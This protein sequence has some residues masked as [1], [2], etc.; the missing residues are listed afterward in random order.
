MKV[1]GFKSEKLVTWNIQKYLINW[2]R[3]VSGP[4]LF[5]KNFLY[6][7]WKNCIVIEEARIPSS[8]LRLDLTNLTKKIIVE[9]SPDKVHLEFNKFMHGGRAG[10]LKKLKADADKMV[11]A[12]SNGFLFVELYDED[13]KNLSVNYLKEKFGVNL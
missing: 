4:Q 3:K 10:F 13:L 11:W 9:I 12:E 6:P 2:E 5:V 1:K 8:L 7:Y